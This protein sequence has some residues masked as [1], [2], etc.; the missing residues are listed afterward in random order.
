MITIWSFDHIENKHS[1]YCGEDCMKQFCESLRE[2]AKN[3]T[4]LEK[5][6][7]FNKK[8]LN[9]RQDATEFYFCRKRFMK[10]FAKDK[11]YQKLRDHCHF[12]G[13]YRGAPHIYVIYDFICLMKLL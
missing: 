8:K 6:V 3:I 11:I 7:V 12:T 4:D 9:S 1:L 13:K 5:N 2:H 10:R